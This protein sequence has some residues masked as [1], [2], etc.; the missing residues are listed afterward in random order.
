MMY[1]PRRISLELHQLW[2]LKSIY[3]CHYLH[4]FGDVNL[5]QMACPPVSP[6]RCD[7]FGHSLWM[8]DH[9]WDKL[10]CRDKSRLSR[11]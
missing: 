11:G 7:N 4:H 6:Y 1:Q 8:S 10:Q 3:E 5:L 2:K 9:T